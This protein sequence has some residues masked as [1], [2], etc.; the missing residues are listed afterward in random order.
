MIL[1][2]Q[3]DERLAGLR[4]D[5]GCVNHHQSSGGQA[6]GSNKM[7]N[8]ERIFGG[9]LVVL[10]VGNQRPAEVGGEDFRRL[11]MLAANVDLPDPEGPMR[12]T[13]ESSGMVSFTLVSCPRLFDGWGRSLRSSVSQKPPSG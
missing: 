9:G 2:G 4:L 10:V 5:V 13:S 3:C 12:T 6:L 1:A 8:L 7:Q 11:E